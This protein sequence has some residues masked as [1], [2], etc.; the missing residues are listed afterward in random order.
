MTTPP[1]WNEARPPLRKRRSIID[2]ILTVLLGGVFLV[3]G[4]SKLFSMEALEWAIMDFGIP[5]LG[6]AGLLARLLIGIEL[7][8]GGF[9]VAHIALRRFTLPATFVL[10]IGFVLYLLYIYAVQGGARSCG[11]FGDWIE[12]KPWQS[13]TKN[14]VMLLVTG[15]LLR[16]PRIQ[17]YRF[18]RILAALLLIAGLATP[19]IV[20]PFFWNR[21]AI[22]IDEP[23]SLEALYQDPAQAPATNLREGTHLM[24]FLSLNCVHCQKAAFRLQT[25]YEQNP[26][27][28]IYFVLVGPEE[29][30]EPFFEITQARGV[31]YTYME[32]IDAFVEMAGPSVPAIYWVRDGVKE[33]KS[34]YG[35]LDPIR[36]QQWLDA[37]PSQP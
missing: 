20:D 34:H 11:C 13:L 4:I 26:S 6:V 21:Q 19:F 8:L 1:N 7:V 5:W 33:K 22:P 9:L 27:W 18:Y 36:I 17:P 30:L 2:I 28:P 16:R 25:L 29:S 24:A 3:S 37:E 32:D 31:P 10:L 14:G 35:Q 23:I 15:Y 12:L